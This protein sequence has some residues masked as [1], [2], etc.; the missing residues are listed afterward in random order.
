MQAM[1]RKNSLIQIVEIVR[2]LMWKKRQ[3]QAITMKNSG[4]NES[5]G[6][7]MLLWSIIVLQ[8]GHIN[9]DFQP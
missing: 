7:G 5:L 8:H 9:Q 2:S 3:L 4:M 6:F 1:H